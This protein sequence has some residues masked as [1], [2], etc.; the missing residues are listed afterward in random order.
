MIHCRPTRMPDHEVM[1]ARAFRPGHGRAR[2]A[3]QAAGRVATPTAAVL[4]R[5]L[6]A[7]SAS[8][9][10]GWSPSL[11]RW[12][13]GII[14]SRGI[15]WGIFPQPLTSLGSTTFRVGSDSVP[16]H[17]GGVAR[18]YPELNSADTYKWTLRPSAPGACSRSNE[19]TV[20]QL[21][22]GRGLHTAGLAST[23]CATRL[24]RLVQQGLRWL[25]P[26]LNR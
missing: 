21:G 10:A 16:R 26:S 17:N 18:G 1:S 25:G 23:G 4:H 7:A 22:I 13:C 6:R 19:P 11:L 9:C 8:H 14:F 3:C 20:E 5:G 15:L 24:R 2:A 12:S